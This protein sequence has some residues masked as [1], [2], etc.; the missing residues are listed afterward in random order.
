MPFS[1]SF[2]LPSSSGP[3][4]DVVVVVV[5][6]VVGAALTSGLTSGSATADETLVLFW[7]KRLGNMVAQLLCA[8]L[9]AHTMRIVKSKRR[10]THRRMTRVKMV[11]KQERKARQKKK[12][13][14][15]S[16]EERQRDGDAMQ[17]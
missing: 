17:R 2:S 15:V 3:S 11:C 10:T 9:L 1:T 4:G 6:A 14:D 8:S 16:E 13:N 5:V 7:K 12:N